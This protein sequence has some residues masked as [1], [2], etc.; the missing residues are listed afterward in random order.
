MAGGIGFTLL[1]LILSLICIRRFRK[2]LRVARKAGNVLRER[3]NDLL[4]ERLVL[5][6]RM[7][8]L[9]A[10]VE[11]LS[12]I[13]EVSLAANDDVD[14]QRILEIVLKI[15]ED[16]VGAVEIVIFLKDEAEGD[17]TARVARRS[18]RTLFEEDLADDD[19]DIDLAR[20]ALRVSRLLRRVEHGVITFMTLLG[21]DKELFG[22]IEVKVAIRG[23]GS[24]RIEEIERSLVGLTK[25]IALAIRKPTLYDRAVL[26]GLTGLYSKR[27][28][29]AQLRKY[30]GA[31]RRLQKPLS[32]LMLDIDHFKK[33]ND[34]FGHLT[35]DRVLKR[36]AEAIRGSIR[37]Y[38][39]AYRYGGEEIA[40][41]A[42][43]S[44]LSEALIM[45]ERVRRV[46][47]S[48]DFRDES[49]QTFQVTVSIGGAEFREEMGDLRALITEADGCLY[50]AKRSGRNRV[51]PS[52]KKPLCIG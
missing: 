6:K 31:S 41:I 4:E 5:R 2:N 44:R 51:I 28:F 13:R 3:L 36:V 21:A 37:E 24:E 42:P 47:A 45:A 9:E 20:E 29:L 18:G 14:F 49:G 35:G 25:H 16:L 27:H 22:A 1:I 15:I 50:E 26:D 32:L 10:Q 43:E 7:G 38:D 12:A 34:R 33:I 17:L 48:I 46:V 39:S 30:F 52:L 40:I 11:M 8:R 23:L 19:L